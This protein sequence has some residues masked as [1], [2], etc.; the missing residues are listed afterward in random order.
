MRLNADR[1]AAQLQHILAPA[2]LISGDEPLLVSEAAASIRDAARARGFSER[3]LHT[4]ER[5]FDWN[6]LANASDNLS[7]FADKRIVELRLPT[8]KP[9]KEGSAVI[10][11][12]AE[13][14]VDDRL[15]LVITG[16][17]DRSAAAAKWAKAIEKNGVVVQVWPID[18]QRL[19]QWIR[20]RMQKL[21]LKASADAVQLL[22]DRVEGNLLAAQQEIDKLALLHR[23][24]VI[25]A[26]AVAHSVADSS[27]YDVFQ[28]VDAADLGDAARSLKILHGLRAEGVEPVLVLWALAREIRTL[29]SIAWKIRNGT[30]ENTVL[31]QAGVWERR[32]PVIRGAL[33]RHTMDSLHRALMTAAETDFV[34]KGLEPG[35]PWNALEALVAELAGVGVLRRAV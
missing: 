17:L 21:D 24:G 16:K 9:G 29:A 6:G 31:N 3:E 10:A 7:L 8:G 5:S 14:P 4:V 12:L 19:P 32:K 26:E 34:I 18:R 27:H 2:Y 11:G 25:D 30:P 13:R 22:A 33:S 35:R 28:L 15:L 23:D 1:L 20:L